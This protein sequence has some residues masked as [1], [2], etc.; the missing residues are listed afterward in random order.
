MKLQERMLELK[1][2]HAAK[3]KE[4]NGSLHG[5]DEVWKEM[6]TE[7][8]VLAHEDIQGGSEGSGE[9]EGAEKKAPDVSHK[10]EDL[11]T[12]EDKVNFI[13]QYGEEAYSDLVLRSE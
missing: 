2:I 8:L 9:G 7:V 5:F 1:A 3:Y 11:R 10:L 13:E 6:E 12:I 4:K